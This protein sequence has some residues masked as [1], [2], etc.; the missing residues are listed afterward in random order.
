MSQLQK[1]FE[2]IVVGQLELK[3]RL[4][5]PGVADNY[6]AN[7]RPS[8][9]MKA[10]YAEIARGGVALII[11]GGMTATDPVGRVTRGLGIYNDELIASLRELV[12]IVHRGGAKLAAQLSAPAVLVTSAGDAIEAVGPSDVV[13]NRRTGLQPRPVTEDEI[14]Q[15]VDTLGEAV[16]R[17]RDAGFDAVEFHAGVG[18]LI[19]QFISP[20][21]NKRTDKYGGS[22]ENRLRF[23]LEI[24]DMARR[25]AGGDYT[26]LARVSGADF[27]EGGHTLE[28]TM[29]VAPILERAGIQAIDVTTGWHEAPVPSFHASVPRGNWAYLAEGVKKV[30]S[31]P[32]ITGTRVPDP[33]LA[34]RI[35]VEGKAD[36]VY[37]ARPLIADPELPDKAAAGRLAEIRPCIACSRCFST[38]LRGEP[39]V[40]TV[41]ARAGREGEYRLDPTKQPQKVLVIGGGPAGMEAARVAAT[42]GHRVT[43]M[44]KKE[45]LGGQLP[46]AKLPPYKEEIGYFVEYLAGQMEK[47]DIEVRLG[48]EVT[49]TTVKEMAPDVVVVAT[50]AAPIVPDVPGAAGSNVVTAVDVL[51][52][53]KE[54]GGSVIIMGGG[55]VG[56]ETAE[57]LAQKGKSVT[58]LEVLERIGNDFERTNRWVVMQ[59]LRQAQVR[60]ETRVEVKE[61]AETGVRVEREGEPSFIEAD[62]IVLAVGMKAD[63]RL[64]DE[65]KNEVD[66]LYVIGDNAQP[67]GIAEAVESGLRTGCML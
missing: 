60:L 24:I 49:A 5:R 21:T 51:T 37:M 42:R 8:E 30:V 15:I 6:A 61:I 67:Q 63:T 9:R 64:A 48:E 50:G 26:L 19:N 40:C 54:V 56:C 31:I 39:M 16:R 44:E 25:K 34:D 52:G 23:F 55:R 7:E 12:E 57:F 14:K 13:V 4:V 3:N 59:R 10:F 1:L 58:I 36:L 32:V 33:I 41:N 22:L 11:T 65:L 43:L 66:T 2:P 45:A 28:D 18:G 27:V 62:N 20:N 46:V 38:I 53:N 47:L 29:L 17:A 35:L